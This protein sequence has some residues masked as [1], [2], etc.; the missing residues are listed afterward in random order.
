MVALDR[1]PGPLSFTILAWAR[2]ANLGRLCMELH[3]KRA[4]QQRQMHT[5]EQVRSALD[6]MTSLPKLINGFLVE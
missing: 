6:T 5:A 4:L 3:G 2:E 1:L